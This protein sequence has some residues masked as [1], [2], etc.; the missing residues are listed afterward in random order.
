MIFDFHT[1]ISPVCYLSCFR[2]KK[3]IKTPKRKENL[4][5]LTQIQLSFIIGETEAE[6]Y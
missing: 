6:F 3:G 1:N 4:K 5:E 2:T